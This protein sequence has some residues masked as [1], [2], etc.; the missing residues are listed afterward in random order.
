MRLLGVTHMLGAKTIEPDHPPLGRSR[1]CRRCGSP[2]SA[3]PT[4]AP[5][6]ASTASPGPCRAPSWS[7]P[8]GWSA[9]RTPRSTR[10]P[11]PG[12]DARSVA[13]T[14]KPVDGV[15]TTPAG[16]LA[17]AS[18]EIVS[19]EPERVVVQGAQ[20]RPGAGGARRQP[21]PGLEGD[22]RRQGRADV[23]RV[24]YLFRGVKVGAGQHT[25]VFRYEPLSW[26]IGWIVSLVSLAGL[27][28][29]FAVGLRRQRRSPGPQGDPEPLDSPATDPA[30]DAAAVVGAARRPDA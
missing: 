3:S 7:E 19:Y 1:P 8:S 23:E 27:L 14:E 2:A 4:T 28:L 18:A 6:P 16:C 22:G 25:V 21:L 5:T 24:D 15:P 20:R 26:R 11:R 12:F 13:I 29:A 17:P 10:S 9:A 30:P